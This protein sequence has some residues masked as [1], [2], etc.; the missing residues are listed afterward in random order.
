MKKINYLL[1][2]F[3]AA[4]FITSCNTNDLEPTLAQHKD[5][6]NPLTKVDDLYGFIK[7][8]LSQM[9]SDRYYG[10]DFI[11]NNEVRTD[12][13][14]SN[15]ASGRFTTQSDFKY[16]NRTGFIWGTAYSVISNANLIINTDISTLE[17]DANR[18]KHI[19]GQAYMLRALVHFD[20]LK[21]YGQQHVGGTLGVPYMTK[22]VSNSSPKE[23]LYL[24]RNTVEEVKS[25]IFKDLKSAFDLMDARR[26]S[27][28]FPSKNAAKALESRVALYFEMYPEAKAA[29]EYVINTRKYDIMDAGLFVKSWE[30]K[31]NYNSIFELAFN[32]TDNRGFNSLAYI[33][34]KGSNG[35]YGD[36]Q[37]VDAVKDLFEAGDVRG[38]GGILGREGRGGAQLRNMGKYPNMLGYDNVPL[39][40][41]EEVIL[42]YAEALLKTGGDALTQLNLI[43]AKRGASA[44][45]EATMEN[46]LLE[47]RKELMFEGFR[48]DDLMRTKQDIKRT[49]GASETHIPYGNYILA[50]AIP[51][52][53]LDANS[54]MKQNEGY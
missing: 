4:L 25:M 2:V 12:N 30:G 6:K 19:Q 49:Q 42:N 9:T 41:I 52:R 28:V 24:S 11:I 26:A 43:P 14:F 32:A 40:R 50:W 34:R 35:R 48:F 51:L 15:G 3:V 37:T 10:R 45:T 36:V 38:L 1:I 7:G 13:C 21:M 46:I 33:Y 54:N 44:Y 31:E 17:G 39:I 53:E 8:T 16:D 29:A 20:L 23:D 18:A 27:K 47:R 22:F 5:G